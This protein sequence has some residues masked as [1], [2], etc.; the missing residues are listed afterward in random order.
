MGKMNI[1]AIGAHPDDIEIGCG[2]TII[3]YADR[4]H[5]LFSLVMTGGGQGGKTDTRCR[6]Q[7]GQP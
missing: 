6:E 2:G 3:K 5:N 1:L 7:E 4:G